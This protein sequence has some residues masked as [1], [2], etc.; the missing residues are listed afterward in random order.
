MDPIFEEEVGV[1][2]FAGYFLINIIY[3]ILS[4]KFL[5]ISLS[6]P[7]LIGSDMSWESEEI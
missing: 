5:I 2:C 1:F 3:R 4:D 6:N 7:L